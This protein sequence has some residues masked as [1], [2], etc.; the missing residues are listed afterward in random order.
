MIE[1]NPCRFNERLVHFHVI[2]SHLEAEVGD[3]GGEAIRPQ[4]RHHQLLQTLVHLV[5]LQRKTEATTEQ[6]HTELL[7]PI[8]MRDSEN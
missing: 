1:C 3:D 5:V 6:K 7:S 4:Q 2:Q 8:C